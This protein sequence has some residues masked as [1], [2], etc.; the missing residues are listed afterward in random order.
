M[1]LLSDKD[2]QVLRNAIRQHEEICLV[3]SLRDVSITAKTC[4]VKEPWPTSMVVQVLMTKGDYRWTQ[5][6]QQVE[7]AKRQL[8]EWDE[9]FHWLS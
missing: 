6:F 2:F 5:N 9:R 7:E 3:R 4:R 8:D 1:N